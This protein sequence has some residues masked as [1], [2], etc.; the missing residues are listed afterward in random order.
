MKLLV[1]TTDYE[2]TIE[3]AKQL[4][5]DYDKSVLFHCYWNGSLQEKHFYSIQSC[6]Y[7]HVKQNKTKHKIILWLEKNTPNQYN[8]LIEKYAEIRYFNLNYEI[9]ETPL[10]NRFF[11]FNTVLSF[12]SDVVR[13]ILLYK[14]GGCWF[15][16]DCFF[17]RSL[18][19]LFFHYENQICVYQ[20]ENQNYPNGAIYISLE[21]KSEKMKQTIEFIADRNRGWGFQE[22]MLTY[23]LPLELL[24][25]P[26]SWFDASWIKNPQQITCD[27]F[28]QETDK[29][30]DFRDFFHGA[31]CYHWHNRW[32]MPI[33]EKSIMK[34]LISKM[35]I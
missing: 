2:K 11:R 10:E 22:A 15:D 16:L 23:D 4:T 33:H 31:F 21:P 5:G 34:Q 28:F 3:M 27:M 13:Y 17:L 24:V 19:P 18:D 29:Q 14:Y 30:Y 7:F 9:K 35:N 25:L 1:E 20:W 26:C 8:S 32:N 12:F 6:Y